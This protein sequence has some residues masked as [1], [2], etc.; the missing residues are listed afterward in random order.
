M[1]SKYLGQRKYYYIEFQTKPSPSYLKVVYNQQ[2]GTYELTSVTN[3]S[4]A[5]CFS[6]YLFDNSKKYIYVS[7]TVYLKCIPSTTDS[8]TELVVSFVPNSS[9]FHVEATTS[10]KEG[11]MYAIDAV[12]DLFQDGMIVPLFQFVPEKFS[13]IDVFL[14]TNGFKNEKIM[15]SKLYRVMFTHTHKGLLGELVGLQSTGKWYYDE[16]SVDLIKFLDA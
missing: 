16:M 9:V 3:K 6:P 10:A 12:S 8:G 11:V 1:S 15:T 5:S 13:K 14:G 2:N 7:D 4:I